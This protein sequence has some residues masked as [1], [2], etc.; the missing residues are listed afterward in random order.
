MKPSL[1]QMLKAPFY[2]IF[3]RSLFRKYG[4]KESIRASYVSTQIK[5]VFEEY[6][7]INLHLVN[8][9]S[10]YFLQFIPT[11]KRVV[12]SFWGTDLL[13]PPAVSRQ[14]IAK[15]IRRADRITLHTPEMKE[16]FLSKYGRDLIDKVK[17]TLLVDDTK[18]L[19][20]VIEHLS[21][22]NR[23]IEEFK[24]RYSISLDKI[25]VAIGHSGHHGDNHLEV[26]KNLGSLSAEE[27]AKLYLVLPMTYG[28]SDPTY[29]DEIEKTSLE[30]GLKCLIFKEYL[31]KKENIELRLVSEIH[32]RVP[33]YDAFSLALSETICSDNIIVTATWLPYSRLRMGGVYYKEISEYKQLAQLMSNILGNFETEQL[34]HQNNH[35][36]IVSMFQQENATEKFYNVFVN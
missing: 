30:L 21:S 35:K 17:V 25:I 16:I 10:L 26:I 9:H 2:S 13:N 34:K 5:S 8:K 18:K 19:D 28:C 24:K 15:Y 22:K 6:D 27:K 11:N 12:F 23:I 33:K 14:L 7:V 20:E 29:F 1:S 32:I 4:I 3:Y 36:A 31:P